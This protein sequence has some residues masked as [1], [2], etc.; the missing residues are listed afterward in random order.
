[1]MKK[2]NS[3]NLLLYVPKKNHM[4]WELKNNKV[5]LIFYHK[6]LIE[7]IMRW[8]V[9]KPLVTDIKLDE[10]G[11]FIWKHIDGK[12]TIYEIGENLKLQF[13]EKCEPIYNRLIMYLRYLNRM[14][15]IAF[16]RGNQE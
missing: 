1:M 4:E 16:E 3:D 13:G 10:I 9:K 11:S 14:G 7:R 8:L 6:K 5:Y 2:R 15:W 12:E